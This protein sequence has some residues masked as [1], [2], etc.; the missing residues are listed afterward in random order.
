MSNRDKALFIEELT[1][2][3]TNLRTS[4]LVQTIIVSPSAFCCFIS[5]NASFRESLFEMIVPRQV[6]WSNLV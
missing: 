4:S 1:S 6:F 3:L 2:S 5:S